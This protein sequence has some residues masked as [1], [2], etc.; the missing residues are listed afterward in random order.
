MDPTAVRVFRS[1]L[2]VEERHAV[3]E[4]LKRGEVRLVFTT[5]ALELGIDI[6]GL[7][8]IIMAGFPDSLMSAWQRIGRA[9]RNWDAKAFVL[10]FARNNPLDRFY[11]ANLE[12]CLRKPL[13]NLVVNAENEDLVEKHLGSLLFE[14][15]VLT[16][17]AAI[18]GSAMER[19]VREK[20]DSGATRSS[21]ASGGH[22]R[23]EHQGW[24][25]RH[26]RPQ[27]GQQ[28]DRDAFRAPTVPRSIP[29]GYLHAW[30]A[31]LPG[32]GG[33]VEGRRWRDCAGVSRPLA[34]DARVD[35]YVCVG[36]GH[37]RRMAMGWR[38]NG[39]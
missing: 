36:T 14:T 22:P 10:Y 9:G 35:V 2:A 3:Q 6:G 12:A 16:D 29:A 17:D 23:L 11:A 32:E 25:C 38:G 1:G 34:T 26:V 7:D 21:P 18:L 13:D 31:Q 28:G 4:G 39:R 33:G 5:N 19:E 30:R 15:P 27:G 8:G 24:R 37:F 20:I